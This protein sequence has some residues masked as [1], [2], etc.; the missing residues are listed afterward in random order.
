M[1]NKQV[2]E[3]R[4]DYFDSFTGLY[5]VEVFLT[6][7]DDE[8]GMSIATV[9]E[10]GQVQFKGLDRLDGYDLNPVDKAIMEVR[11][12]IIAT[13]QSLIDRCLEQIKEDVSIG[14]L[15]AIDELLMFLPAKYLKGYL[16]E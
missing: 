11:D 1:K 12:K 14:D 5:H 13:K 9:D 7:N 8:E 3:V 6:D 4:N 2:S 15:T 16:P 10:D